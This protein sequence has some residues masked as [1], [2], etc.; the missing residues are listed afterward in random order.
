MERRPLAFIR[1][2]NLPIDEKPGRKIR[3]KPD[4][5]D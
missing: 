2:R 3:C 5:T 4:R 1:G